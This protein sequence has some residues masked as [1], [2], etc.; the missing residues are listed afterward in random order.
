[1]TENNSIPESSKQ[2]HPVDVNHVHKNRGKNF[3]NIIIFLGLV[4]IYILFFLSKY[5]KKATEL[6]PPAKSHIS[7]T[8][9]VIAFVNTDEIMQKYELVQAMKNDLNKKMDRME[10]EILSKQTA[11]ENDANYF[12]EQVAKKS[13]SEKSAQLIYE[14]LME[15][16]QKLID[17]RD[18]YTEQLALEEY[19]MNIILVDSITNFLKRYNLQHNYD[20]VLGYSK[21]GGIL[22]AKDT[23]NITN[24]VLSVMNREYNSR[25][26][27]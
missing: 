18:K 22:L 19:D 14:K 12:Q 3:F 11:Y 17:L 5:D 24:E 2:D 20:Y 6:P 1:M 15:E 26:K 27:E 21:G 7:A 4:V 25:M 16:Q 23:F 8:T 13:I 9:N 10:A